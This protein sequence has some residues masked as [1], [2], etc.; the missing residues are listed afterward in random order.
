MRG[1]EEVA[2]G[3]V[4]VEGADPRSCDYRDCFVILARRWWSLQH[5]IPGLARHRGLLVRKCKG[6]TITREMKMLAKLFCLSMV[7]SSSF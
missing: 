4:W 6:I 3:S 5:V 1:V 7:L 2:R